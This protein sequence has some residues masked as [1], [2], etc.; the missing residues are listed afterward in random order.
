MSLIAKCLD[1]IKNAIYG[2]EVRQSIVDAI[3]QC[4]KDATGN[5]ESVAA[6][7]DDINEINDDIKNINSEVE[8]FQE[9]VE[10]VVANATAGSESATNSEI[11][12]ARKGE[13]SL[14][15]RLDKIEKGERLNKKSISANKLSFIDTDLDLVNLYKPATSEVGNILSTNGANNDSI[16]N[17]TRT[18]YI[19]VKDNGIVIF[20]EATGVLKKD[21]NRFVFLYDI[22]KNIG[23]NVSSAEN[24]IIN[25]GDNRVFLKV[26]NGYKY[27]RFI[28][29]NSLAS[30][31]IG[32]LLKQGLKV[33]SI[34]GT[35]NSELL[36]GDLE[37]K[38]NKMKGKTI[39]FAGN[40]ITTGY[41]SAGTSLN[42]PFPQK[43]RELLHCNAINKGIGATKIA[44]PVG[45]KK[46]TDFC[47]ATRYTDF[48]YPEGKTGVIPDVICIFGGINDHTLDSPLGK[49]TD[50]DETTFYGA[51]KVMLRGLLNLI[52]ND[53]NAKTKTRICMFTPMQRFTAT[54]PYGKFGSNASDFFWNRYTEITAEGCMNKNNL[55][56]RVKDYVTAIKEVC[57]LYGIP[58]LDLFSCSAIPSFLLDVDGVH[59][60]QE[61]SDN[62]LAVKICDFLNSGMISNYNSFYDMIDSDWLKKGAVKPDRTSF[63]TRN[64]IPSI[65]TSSMLSDLG[66]NP[67]GIVKGKTVSTDPAIKSDYYKSIIVPLEENMNYRF[68]I[69]NSIYKNRARVA[70]FNIEPQTGTQADLV[71]NNDT[72]YYDDEM[73]FIVSNTTSKYAIVTFYNDIFEYDETPRIIIQK[74]ENSNF[75]DTY[76]LSKE[77]KLSEGNLANISSYEEIKKRTDNI[78]S[79][80]NSYKISS[81]KDVI[82]ETGVLELNEGVLSVKEMTRNYNFIKTLYNERIK[83]IIQD[84]NY[85]LIG[86]GVNKQG[87]EV[88][89]TVCLKHATAKLVGYITEWSNDGYNNVKAL[90]ISPA[91]NG[92]E[93]EIVNIIDKI[94]FYKNSTYWF[95]ID[96]T[97]YPN[98]YGLTK[99]VLGF[100]GVNGDSIDLVKN[101]EQK[102][103]TGN[104]IEEIA[105]SIEDLKEEFYEEETICEYK[106][107]TLDNIKAKGT[108]TL[109]DNILSLEEAPA[110]TYGNIILDSQA[111]NFTILDT[112]YLVLGT[113][114]NNYFT[115]ICL[116]HSN[117]S[118]VGKMND[119]DIPNNNSKTKYS[120]SI[121]PCKVGDIISVEIVNNVYKLKKNGNVWFE[122]N[123]ADYP[124][125]ANWKDSKLGF[126]VTP[127]AYSNLAKDIEIAT[128]KTK[129]IT[130]K[131]SLKKEIEELNNKIY[132]GEGTYEKAVVD[133]FDV[134]SGEL[135]IDNQYVYVLNV[136]DTYGYVAIKTNKIYFTIKNTNY[137]L[138]GINGDEF[139]TICL[140]HPKSKLVGYITRWSKSGA[141]TNYSPIAMSPCTEGDEIDITFEND[142]YTFL[143]N[144]KSWFEINV[145]DYPE[146]TGW[147][148]KRLGFF[149]GKNL[150]NEQLVKDV[151]YYNISLEPLSEKVK[152]LED[153]IVYKYVE[154]EKYINVQESDL[155]IY[156]NNANNGLTLNNGSL[157]A[158]P[159]TTDY[160]AIILQ[161]EKTSMKFNVLNATHV[162][163]GMQDNSFTAVCI[164]ECDFDTVGN[165]VDC[166]ET[167]LYGKYTIDI[168]PCIEGDEIVVEIKDG[169][170]IFQKN[171]AA[172]FTIEKTK[173]PKV[174]RW[175]TERLG[176]LASRTN[177]DSL[178]KLIKVPELTNEVVYLKEEID[179]IKNQVGTSSGSRWR[180]KRLGFIGDSLMAGY[181]NPNNYSFVIK[182]AELLGLASYDLN[183]I[184]GST[185]SNTST[186]E[187]TNCTGLAERYTELS[188]C[189][190][191]VIFAGTN[192]Y[193]MHPTKIGEKT[194][195]TVTT[196]YGGLNVLI[197]GLMEKFPGKPIYFLTPLHRQKDKVELGEDTLANKYGHTLNDYRE[198]IINRCLHYGVEYIDCF[199]FRFNPNIAKIKALYFQDIAHLN[200][201][202]ADEFASELAPRIGGSAGSNGK[203]AYEIAK[204]KGFEGTEAE[205][206]ESL[207]GTGGTTV[208]LTSYQPKTDKNLNTASK[209]VVG[210]INELNNKK[211]YTKTEVDTALKTKAEANNVY[212]KNEIDT[213]L[214]G[215]VDK[216]DGK[217]LSSN[218]FTD[219]YKEKLD[220]VD[221]TLINDTTIKIN[222]T[223]SSSK[224]E[225]AIKQCLA[226]S[227]AYTLEDIAKKT[228]ATYKIVANESKVV[229]SEYLYLVGNDTDGYKIYAY[230][231]D[232]VV[233]LS[234]DTISLEGYVKKEDGKSLVL[235]TEI[236]KIHGHTN[237]DILDKISEDADGNILYDGESIKTDLIDDTKTST[238]TTYSANKIDSIKTDLQTKIDNA[239]TGG[240]V[241]LSNYYD[242]NEV[243]SNFATKDHNHDTIYRKIENSYSKEEIDAKG[244]LTEHQDV[245][246]KQEKLIAGNNI[247]IADNNTISATIPTK[248]WTG[249]KAEYN[250]ITD[251]KDDIT[252]I[253]T[254]EEDNLDI[255]SLVI[256]DTKTSDNTTWSSNKINEENK[257]IYST[258][259]VKTNKIWIDG[260][261]IYRKMYTS[262]D[263]NF[264]DDAQQGTSKT[265]ISNIEDLVNI[266]GRCKATL[267]FVPLNI[268]KWRGD[269][270]SSWIFSMLVRPNGQIILDMGDAVYSAK[271]NIKVVVEYTKTTD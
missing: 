74:S 196:F 135:L 257:E 180:G 240:T 71:F 31:E 211:V 161:E 21:S 237:K 97:E 6:V 147:E 247:T 56:Y 9:Q 124:N 200:V 100:M 256:D 219:K 94:V 107:I 234:N 259:E 130:L 169:V 19:E 77:I 113:N 260:K 226:D 152:R 266:S 225:T 251:K 131:E 176:F 87:Q 15:T 149:I 140:K 248:L 271:D 181:G 132:I 254:D 178:V 121:S 184:S 45:N 187:G 70:L 58:V 48:V 50:N 143:L 92:D 105:D 170:Y 75:V 39:V 91:V 33:Y 168:A 24:W 201:L 14:G 222:K 261:P 183:A 156:N 55:G 54:H 162:V 119:F 96:K 190:G 230:V 61:T 76:S 163:L 89:T 82:C 35:L 155:V 125:V 11:V 46:T 44:S 62:W 268:G 193:G 68:L 236:A 22:K 79:A 242:K 174:N 64:P 252:Y 249:T 40:S 57:S 117:S 269:A 99:S 203:S 128:Y 1:K 166:S 63:L 186:I 123:K 171:G 194:D 95:T 88:R 85:V 202:G 41:T 84:T 13:V 32:A 208:D 164:R 217:G 159:M 53:E 2:R 136:K 198:A 69:G 20:D 241:D 104:L 86:E 60:T 81:L 255:N 270:N 216:V 127:T 129:T 157:N 120:L 213:A 106:N 223:Y 206:L 17:T 224:I 29:S 167:L 23:K 25:E 148:E 150:N 227:K 197:K 103:S 114:G 42:I 265:N 173:Y 28:D 12:T 36:K 172:W 246:G 116:K 263:F 110:T 153:N 160:T 142:V 151:R 111:L 5:P 3:D 52:K 199:E 47:Q 27:L 16:T 59:C 83:F 30:S 26:P 141:Y 191:Y 134:S 239:I 204:E 10:R 34:S 238:N 118:F 158:S 93:I 179:N 146:L 109:E 245:S 51:L 18:A 210:A 262:S 73:E 133:S 188:E 244:Y 264:T 192:D 37:K 267:Y 49:L 232:T 228:S 138:L 101:L 7:V 221:N 212:N 80:I 182:L 214:D 209:T 65:Y 258:D 126:L 177:N 235:D 144:G 154:K 243:D 195:T 72:L 4:Y 233:K 165:L 66:L 98:D 8:D 250:A 231:D 189:D 253:V 205:W 112:H 43:I 137:A 139:V 108:V 145:K 115:S 220:L 102:E 229:S 218:D 38:Y 78:S 122:I 185:I 215:K 90:K 207:K 67:E 175:E